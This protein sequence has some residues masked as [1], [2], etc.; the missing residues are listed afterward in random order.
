M[1][2]V[3]LFVQV[4]HFTKSTDYIGSSNGDTIVYMLDK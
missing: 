3:F 4:E 1:P 2:S